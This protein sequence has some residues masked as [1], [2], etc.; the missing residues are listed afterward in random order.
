MSTLYSLSNLLP[1]VVPIRGTN[2]TTGTVPADD[3]YYDPTLDL[4]TVGEILIGDGTPYHFPDDA[5]Y[6]GHLKSAWRTQGW[7][8]ATLTGLISIT[9]SLEYLTPPGPD[10]WNYSFSDHPIV[11]TLSALEVP[12]ESILDWMGVGGTTPDRNY[13]MSEMPFTRVYQGG[14]VGLITPIVVPGVNSSGNVGIPGNLRWAVPGAY[15]NVGNSLL[16]T[17]DTGLLAWRYPLRGDPSPWTLGSTKILAKIYVS[18]YANSACP[19]LGYPHIGYFG[20]TIELVPESTEGPRWAGYP[21]N[22]PDDTSGVE[23]AT[24]IP[25]FGGVTAESFWA[26]DDLTELITPGPAAGT[27]HYGSGGDFS[28]GSFALTGGSTFGSSISIGLNLTDEIVRT[29]L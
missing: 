9:P 6:A 28:K 15:S 13:C 17:I 18:F 26:L 10:V 7:R 2:A 21:I 25:Y 8:T 22:E 1:G 29:G 11:S 16:A 14:G 23:D 12:A 20:I 24:T 19:I 4:S 5:S 27:V 3:V